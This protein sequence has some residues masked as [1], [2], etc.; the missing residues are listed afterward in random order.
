MSAEPQPKRRRI[1]DPQVEFCLNVLSNTKRFTWNRY[2]GPHIRQQYASWIS[3][4]LLPAL[5]KN[6]GL[7]EDTEETIRSYLELASKLNTRFSHRQKKI[8]PALE[9]Y[10]HGC[11]AFKLDR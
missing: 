7:D 5:C 6:I 8:H 1:T 10:P 2:A 9:P 11:L 3:Y 4:G